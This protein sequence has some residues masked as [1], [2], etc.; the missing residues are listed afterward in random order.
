MEVV[1]AE[2]RKAGVPFGIAERLG[3]MGPTGEESERILSF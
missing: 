2:N 3:H 1:G